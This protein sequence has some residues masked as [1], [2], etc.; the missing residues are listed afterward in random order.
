MDRRTVDLRFRA[1]DAAAF[2]AFDLHIRRIDPVLRAVRIVAIERFRDHHALSEQI[3][4]RFVALH[5]ALVAQQLVVEAEIQ[6]M[7]DRVFDAADVLVHR[8]PVS[9]RSSPVGR[10]RRGVAR[11]NSRP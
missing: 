4:R 6:Q 1:D 11:S 7:Q 5:H 9:A 2:I 8:R 10:V 3:D